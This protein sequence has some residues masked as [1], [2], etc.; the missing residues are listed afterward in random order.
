MRIKI[1]KERLLNQMNAEKRADY[2]SKQ[3]R[4]NKG[5]VD[6]ILKFKHYFNKFEPKKGT[7]NGPEVKKSKV[8][9]SVY[10]FLEYEGLNPKLYDTDNIGLYFYNNITKDTI[11]C[12]YVDY[13]KKIDKYEYKVLKENFEIFEKYTE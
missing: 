13:S 4:P 11:P 10:H 2:F 6:D 1:S 5:T 3:Q 8:Y 7:I 9:I 12:F